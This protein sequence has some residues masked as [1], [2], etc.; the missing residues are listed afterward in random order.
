MLA[1]IYF[2]QC[3]RHCIGKQTH[4]KV[5][6]SPLG[7]HVSVWVRRFIHSASI[8][9]PTAGVQVKDIIV[10]LGEHEINGVT[11]LTR[12][13]R[14]FSAGETTTVTVYRNGAKQV[15]TITLD[16]KPQS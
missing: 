14:N 11:S 10:A 6:F 5:R 15:L 9:V 3:S 8:A 16:A 12:A 4:L 2:L 7:I 1:N 13:L